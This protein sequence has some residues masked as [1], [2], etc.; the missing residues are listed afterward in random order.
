[1]FDLDRTLLPETTAERIFIRHLVR[2]RVLGISAAIRTGQYALRTGLRNAVMK[3]RADRPYLAGLHD[4]ALWLHGRTCAREGILPALSD[5][6]I[7]RINEHRESGHEIVLLSGSL[8]Y[9]VEPIAENLG[10][11][12]VICS[13]L[14]VQR[15]RLT[16]R[17]SG[18]H[19]Y[20][21]AKAT[22]MR[23]MAERHGI[24]LDVSYCYADHHTDDL[25]L[26]MFGN[27]VCVNPSEKLRKT[28][29]LRDWRVEVFD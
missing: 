3:I 5:T 6:G 18:L 27:P 8:P 1:M 22:L 16:G 7:R 25:L 10:V 19:P 28:A 15:Q 20:G 4:A 29:R 11:S 24:E 23:A 14:D 12:N 26:E 21:E 9:V 13:H 2:E 17:L